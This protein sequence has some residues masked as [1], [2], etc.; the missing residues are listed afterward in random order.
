[1][2]DRFVGWS[3]VV[4]DGTGC[5]VIR[6]SGSFVSLKRAGFL[7]CAAKW[8]RFAIGVGEREGRRTAVAVLLMLS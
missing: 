2:F 6:P 8:A 7:L 3:G 5:V 4:W 1:M